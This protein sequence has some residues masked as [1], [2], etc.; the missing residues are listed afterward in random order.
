MASGR[1]TARSVGWS[2]P[3]AESTSCACLDGFGEPAVQR[4][5]PKTGKRA[6]HPALPYLAFHGCRDARST[7]WSQPDSQ[8][9]GATR[10]RSH[11]RR[12]D[13]W[14]S[15]RVALHRRRALP[16]PA[17]TPGCPM[18]R[19]SWFLLCAGCAAGRAPAA[20]A[21]RG[22]RRR[23]VDSGAQHRERRLRA[24]LLLR[25]KHRRIFSVCC[26]RWSQWWVLGVSVGAEP[27]CRCRR[28][29]RDTPPR[30]LP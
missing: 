3:P 9:G 27:G 19:H 5:G 17:C 6:R 22:R 1:L 26:V 20:M 18:N 8:T 2:R 7:F 14:R 30:Q 15:R 13:P 4:R 25:L 12:R 11:R 21:R 24:L 23:A 16:S 28:P 29:R 10:S